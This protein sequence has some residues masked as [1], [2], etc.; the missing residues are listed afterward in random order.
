M[1]CCAA[2]FLLA[3]AS[4]SPVVL[5]SS[6]AEA[7]AEAVADV[8]FYV[9]VFAAQGEPNLPSNTHVWATFVRL[10]TLAD[11]GALVAQDT[12]SWLPADY[13]ETFYLSRTAVRGHSFSLDDTLGFMQAQGF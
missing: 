13:A 3:V 11:G 7:T 8:R 2:T 1:L 4:A 12:I 10:T 9:M 6:P 5:S